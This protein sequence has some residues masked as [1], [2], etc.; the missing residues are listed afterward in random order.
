MDILYST[1]IYYRSWIQLVS[2]CVQNVCVY[3]SNS[4]YQYHVKLNPYIIERW[5]WKCA[6]TTSISVTL[7]LFFPHTT[8]NSRQ[9]RKK[10]MHT[11]ILKSNH[12]WAN[13]HTLYKCQ[14]SIYTFLFW[15]MFSSIPSRS[16]N[17]C[18]FFDFIYP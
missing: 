6:K 10:S 12:N 13:E 18:H 1:V 17:Q 4:A 9:K 14:T 8:Q 16:L 2:V 7:V 5:V 3:V 15:L 11:A